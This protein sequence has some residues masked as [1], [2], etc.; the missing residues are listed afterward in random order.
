M[1][2]KKNL[3]ALLYNPLKTS[4]PYDKV[5]VPYFPVL[6]YNTLTPKCNPFI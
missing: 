6:I 5:L 4:V 1:N 2:N 3:I